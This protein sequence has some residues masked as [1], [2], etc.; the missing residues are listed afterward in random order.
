MW[1][2][3]AIY[4]DAACDAKITRAGACGA[5]FTHARSEEG[6]RTVVLQDWRALKD[7][8][9]INQEELLLECSRAKDEPS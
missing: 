2:V 9:N 3:L 1:K 5:S 7:L 6:A 4:W 8:E